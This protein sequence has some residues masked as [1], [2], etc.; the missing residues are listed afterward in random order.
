[1][2]TLKQTRKTGKGKVLKPE[3]YSL[4]Y[5]GGVTGGKQVSA[6]LLLQALASGCETGKKGEAEF[7][8]SAEKVS[9]KMKQTFSLPVKGNKIVEEFTLKTENGAFSVDHES[10]LIRAEYLPDDDN[11]PDRVYQ[12]VQDLCS[13]M[14]QHFDER[15]TQAQ[16]E[17]EYLTEYKMYWTV[18][19]TDN[20]WELMKLNPDGSMEVETRQMLNKE[21]VI[22]TLFVYCVELTQKRQESTRKV[23]D[24]VTEVKRG[25]LKGLK[26]GN[27][28]DRI[29]PLNVE[30]FNEETQ[31]TINEVINYFQVS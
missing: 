17:D 28:Q 19:E 13:G 20:G 27:K 14:N 29:V 30:Q 6:R 12:I 11:A 9:D 1:M 18:E 21:Q 7:I 8:Q 22:Q 23:M 24:L 16:T 15:I 4:Y 31:E 3:H 25:G 10:F 5:N 2:L 26:I